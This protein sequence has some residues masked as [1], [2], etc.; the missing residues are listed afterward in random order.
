[1]RRASCKIS[2]CFNVNKTHV[3]RLT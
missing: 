3:N 1:M 2:P